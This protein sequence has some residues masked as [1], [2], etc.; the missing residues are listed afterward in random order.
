MNII[1]YINLGTGLLLIVVGWLCFFFPNMINP[2]GN[3]SPERKAL[4]DINGLKWSCAIIMT[5]AGGLLLFTALLSFIKVISEEASG[6]LLTVVCMGMVVSLLIA[7]RRHNGWGRDNAGVLSPE[8][9]KMKYSKLTWVIVGL[10]I[11]FVVVVLIFAN[12]TPR[13]EVGEE[14]ISISGMYG[15]DIPLSKILSVELL[16]DMPPISMRTNGSSTGKYNKG[17][18]RLKNGENCLLFIRNQA[19]YIE[20]RTSEDLYY[21]NGDTKE[22]TLGIFSKIEEKTVYKQ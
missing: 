20:L 16:E 21:I 17:H 6:L 9:K 19:P 11:V 5:V 12:K 14:I 10:S 13:I 18:F 7:M 8:S 3:M 1:D 2:Y 15:R 4:V 22:E